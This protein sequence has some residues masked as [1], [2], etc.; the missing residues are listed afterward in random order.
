MRLLRPEIA[1][2]FEWPSSIEDL[3]DETLT[4]IIKIFKNRPNIVKIKNKYLILLKMKKM[5]SKMFLVIK[6]QEVIYLF[7]YLSSL[8][9]LTKF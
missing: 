1:N 4:K 7:K 3:T 5:L 6:P 8:G 9:L 2:T